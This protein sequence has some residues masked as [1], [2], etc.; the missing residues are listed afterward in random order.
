MVGNIVVIIIISGV[1]GARAQ[2]RVTKGQKTSVGSCNR[3][4]P[5]HFAAA[6]FLNVSVHTERKCERTHTHTGSQDLSIQARFSQM[7]AI[8]GVKHKH[9]P[10]MTSSA[11]R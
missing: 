2:T 4:S 8:I 11:E 5:C 7:T 3:I 6:R 1:D 9:A 10:V